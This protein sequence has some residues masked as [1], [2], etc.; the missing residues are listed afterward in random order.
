MIKNYPKIKFSKRF[1]ETNNI[2]LSLSFKKKKKSSHNKRLH[3]ISSSI[4]SLFHFQRVLF[5]FFS[6]WSQTVPADTE[7]KEKKMKKKENK[8]SEKKIILILYTVLLSAPREIF[9]I[10]VSRNNPLTRK[11]RADD[12]AFLLSGSEKL[13]GVPSV[14]PR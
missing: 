5:V 14:F 6:S 12:K 9:S 8:Y 13:P 1:R 11:I 3:F 7:K 4:A 2:L 10:I